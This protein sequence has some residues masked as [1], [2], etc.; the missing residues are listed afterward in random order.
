MKFS[1]ITLGFDPLSAYTVVPICSASQRRAFISAW[2]A[3]EFTRAR[4]HKGI[5]TLTRARADR[6][7]HTSLLLLVIFLEVLLL[8]GPETSADRNLLPPLGFIFF[9]FH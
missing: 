3:H 7:R 8:R 9:S 6:V 4:A 2:H 1:L 5:D